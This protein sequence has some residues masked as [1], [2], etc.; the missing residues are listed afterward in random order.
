[1]LLV[2][3]HCHLNYDVLRNDID[4]VLLRAQ[5]AGVKVMQTICT[6][7]SE[8]HII[9]DLTEKYP[10]LYCSVGVHPNEVSNEGIVSVSNLLDL[11]D[12]EKVIGLGET[13][14]DYYYE[15]S[16]RNSQRESFLN[17][18]E[19]SRKTGLPIIIHNRN[20]DEDMID[21]LKQEMKRGE[22]KALLHCFSSSEKLAK[23]ALDLG[24][25]ISISGI[26]TFKNASPLRDIVKTLPLD[27]LLIETDAPYLAP[28]PMRGKS[29]EPSFV[30]H[31][32]VFLADLIGKTPNNL[33]DITTENF[34]RLF[35]KAKPYSE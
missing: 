14:L 31:T 30:K 4:G 26:V 16:D 20:S 7:I 35:S 15:T 27:R 8:F 3:S 21:I 17:H 33:A 1:M 34:Y 22:F 5:A 19:V 29:N 23:E 9:K 11:T 18:I 6:K 12:H 2:D 10:N 25:Y 24:I 13:G 32:L 28:E